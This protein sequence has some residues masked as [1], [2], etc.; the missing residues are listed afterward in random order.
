[1]W[2]DSPQ[3]STLGLWIS[4]TQ[5]FPSPARTLHTQSIPESRLSDDAGPQGTRL[6]LQEYLVPHQCFR[7]VNNPDGRGGGQLQEIT[8]AF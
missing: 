7:N 3:K 8:K 1:M 6:E 4:S 5:T 2:G